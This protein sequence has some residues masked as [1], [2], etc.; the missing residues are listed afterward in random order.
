MIRG[1]VE[2]LFAQRRQADMV[3]PH[4]LAQGAQTSRTG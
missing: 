3:T 1:L 4:N 2:E